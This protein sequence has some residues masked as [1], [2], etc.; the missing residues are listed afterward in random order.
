MGEDIRNLGYLQWSNDLAWLEKQKGEKWTNLIKE[1]NKRFTSAVSKVDPLEFERPE[2]NPRKLKGWSIEKSNPY[3]LWT[4]LKSGFTSKCWDADFS[5]SLFAAS[6][7]DKDG[8]ERFSLEIYE[9]S[10]SKPRHLT[11]LKNVGPTLAILGKT[12]YFLRSEKDLRYSI[13]ESWCQDKSK[14]LYSLNDE[15]ENLEIRR[16]E[17]TIY[18]IKGDFIKKQYAPIESKIRWANEPPMKSGIVSN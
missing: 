5:D 6:I 7:Q 9:V 4:H 18:C 14:I 2:S 10:D 15:K 17:D 11:T 12:V 8:F 1:E 3:Q 16:G 13:L